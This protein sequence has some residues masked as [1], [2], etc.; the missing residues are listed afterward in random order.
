MKVL[1]KNE[2]HKMKNGKKRLEY[3]GTSNLLAYTLTHSIKNVARCKHGLSFP[4][5][6]CTTLEQW[7]QN[8]LPRNH[9]T[10]T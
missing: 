6:V 2:K 5:P 9:R 10:K 7:L 4:L 8:E 1:E 3:H